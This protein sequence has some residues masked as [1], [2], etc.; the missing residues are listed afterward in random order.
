MKNISA[1]LVLIFFLVTQIQSQTYQFSPQVYSTQGQD[2]INS[3]FQISYTIGEMVAVTTVSNA[4]NT[5]TQGFHQPDKYSVGFESIESLWS[6]Y[7]YPN[8]V[9]DQV[10]LSISS[11]YQA[12]YLLDLFD[13]SGKRILANKKINHLPG[14]QQFSFSTS[15]LAAGAYLLRVSSSEGGN[16]RSFRFTRMP[17]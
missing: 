13:A 8:P 12:N 3:E 15:D 6:G 10:T 16:Q 5:F 17:H 9:D 2:F 11:D 1:F 7:V 14:S 4:S